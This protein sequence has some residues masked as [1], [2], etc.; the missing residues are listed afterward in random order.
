VTSFLAGPSDVDRLV[1]TVMDDRFELVAFAAAGGMGRVYRARDRATGETVAIKLLPRDGDAA[2]FAREAEVLAAIEHPGVVRYLAHGAALAGA[3][4]LAMEWLTGEDL[5]ERLEEGILGVGDTLALAVRVADSL[6]A[7]HRRGI[8]HRDLKP[9][10]LFLVD[11]RL[12]SIK[13]LDFGVARAIESTELTAT[14]A[15]VGTPA[16]MSPEQVRGGVVDARADVYGLGAV[17]FRCLSG[18][19]PFRGAHPLAVFAKVVLEPAPRI[20]T[21]REDV[22][23]ALEALIARLLAKEPEQRPA[24]GAAL[25]DELRVL[26][27]VSTSARAVVRVPAAITAREQRIACVVLCARMADTEATRPEHSHGDTDDA[28]LRAIEQR[29][30]AIDALAK[31]AWIITIPNAASPAEQAVRAAR[32][33]LA[34]AAIRPHAPVFVATGRV[35]V[36]GA[37]RVGEVID[38]AAEALVQAKA[39]GT[40]G[41]RLDVTTAELLA[42]RMRIVGEG[43]WRRLVEEEVAAAP[44]RMLL[45][46]PAACVGRA[47]Q[48]AVLA[49]L[50]HVANT[51][52]RSCAALVVAPPGLGK[53]HLVQE[54]LRTHVL[55]SGDVDVLL[56]SGD[57]IRA[58][59][60]FAVAGQLL[61]YAAGMVDSDSPRLRA[62][63]LE[64]L[65]AGDFSADDAPRM[66]EVLGE[67]CGVYTA[68]ADA[69]P[70]LRAA[71]ADVSTM[72]DVV[73]EAWIDWISARA[74]ERTLL[75]LVEDLH[76][77]DAAS[78]SLIEAAVR[79]NEDR[80]LFFLATA[81]PG[82]TSAAGDRLRGLGLVELALAPLSVR[83]SE[84]LVRAA[85]G[86]RIDEATVKDL[87]RRA[88]GHPFHLEE[89]VR[90]VAAGHGADA[91]PDSVLGMVQARFDDLDPLARRL[92][93][94]ASVFGV[95]FSLGGV[96]ALLGDD[97]SAH[98]ARV[99]LAGLVQREMVT[100]LRSPSGHGGTEYR[101]HHALL[102]DGAYATLADS[103]RVQAHRR[104]A[105]W[106]EA[107]G[108]SDPAVLAEHYDR[109]AA[110]TLARGFFCRA[111]AQALHH[112][113]FE[114]AMAHA[115]RA[116][117]LAP[118]PTGE[119]A[120]SAIEA[121]VLYW[122]GDL[123][124]AADR[125]ADAAGGLAHG[126]R[127][128]FDAVSVAVG[129]L[130]QLGRNEGVATWLEEASR[131]TSS[132]E[133]RGAHIVALC[134]GMTQLFWAHHG[135]GLT[136]VRGCMDA[137]VDRAEG[138]DAYTAGWVHRVH[139]ESAW[140]H[141]HH[142]ERCMTTL[143]ASCDS[144]DRARA[145][146]ALCLTRIN[147]ASLAGWSGA[148]S[149]GLEQVARSRAESEPLGSGFLLRYS[150]IVEALLLAYSGEGAAESAMR[151]ARLQV[152]G[153]PRLSFIGHV[154]VGWLA[155]E[156]GNVEAAD[157]EVTAASSIQV[158]RELRPAALALAA[159]VAWAKG[160]EPDAQRI[161][162]EAAAAESACSDLELTYGT[163]GFALAEAHAA[164]DEPAARA[165]L[166]PV[167]RRLALIASTI[168]SAE[169]RQRFWQRPLPNASIVQLAVRL[170]IEIPAS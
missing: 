128:W 82:D 9:S 131:V 21:I 30:G 100:E 98:A 27:E 47:P 75:I 81:R 120:L 167:V 89:L 116:R 102:R 62:K 66:E 42:G 158:A 118:D 4:Y 93:R 170:G 64:A 132:P 88:G 74:A 140:L 152:K 147:A 68:Q 110:F 45:G 15:M 71:R 165:A 20:G 76:W 105:D 142:I 106:L 22:P 162:A 113:D 83:A 155:L 169:L 51:E 157:T 52:L 7:A 29:G 3:R 77:A 13:L 109:G 92:L 108:E 122:R 1:G 163:A 134:R 115:E 138:I 121:E 11:G 137:L 130:G 148:W 101:F 94:A 124:A 123:V 50:L 58:T 24:D 114:R 85:L 78:V 59:S 91:L 111:A 19:P 26:S 126:A 112:N 129:A 28:V 35:L 104:A 149:R 60:S 16:Y 146:R 119:A 38:R 127:A 80:P 133:N 154:V 141:E 151:A 6:A 31:G 139:G 79:A 160:N 53:S 36:D 86:D 145:L 43:E 72:A 73:R 70:A 18:Y 99:A 40:A 84:H 156:S 8:V 161:G 90:A 63:R 17:M 57:P 54:L 166:T 136:H 14:G 10:N 125:A 32:C 56:A 41:V 25:V 144:F 48:L 150:Q 46:K 69:S 33:A 67:I 55:S 143:E 61:R 103:D 97:L 164:R 65:V 153:S 168:S 5:S 87:A 39:K 12:D 96:V 117:A 44:V 159:R 135:G 34:L 49:A 107:H 2:R 23:P 37:L 95:T